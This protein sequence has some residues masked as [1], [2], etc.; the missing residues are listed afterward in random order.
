MIDYY[1]IIMGSKPACF[2]TTFNQ[3]W[4]EEIISHNLSYE[5]AYQI[6]AGNRLRPLLMAWGYYAN[7]S[8]E[9]NITIANYAISI[10]LIHKAS[11]LLDDLIDNDEARHGMATFHIQYSNS[12]ALL[13][14]IYLLNRGISRIRKNH[15]QYNDLYTTALLN[16]INDMVCGGIKEVRSSNNFLSISDVKEIISLETATLIENSFVLGYRLSLAKGLSIPD[17][18]YN[19]GH[20]CGYCF[21]I[22]NDIEPFAAPEINEKYKGAVNYDFIKQRKNIIISF[23]YGSCTQYERKQLLNHTSFDYIC[24]LINKYDILQMV[25]NEVHMSITSIMKSTM[26]LKS[27]NEHFYT[28]FVKFIV[29][30]FSICFHKCQLPIEHKW[31]DY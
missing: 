11:I 31:F 13:Y 9:N 14:A 29:E 10:E 27:R 26:L 30:M 24:K 12:E 21:Q 16:V 1:N 25:I 20:Q 6:R 18:I 19:I 8:F 3:L 23:L 17:D 7:A 28:S 22:L 2:L 5:D 15:L 4:T